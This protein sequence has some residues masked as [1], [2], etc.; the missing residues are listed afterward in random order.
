M[1]FPAYNPFMVE[2]ARCARMLSMKELSDKTD[3]AHGRISKI[4][5]G[6]ILPQDEEIKK[7][8]EELDFPISFFSQ[9]P[10]ERVDFY[11]ICGV[12]P[13]NYMAYPV[14]SSLNRPPLKPV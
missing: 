10:S 7:L 13:I 9:W 3:I 12:V 8:S 4:E 5:N 11:S 1:T 6:L 2:V 14:I